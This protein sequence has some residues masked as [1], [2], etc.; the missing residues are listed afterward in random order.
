MS[1]RTDHH[2][3]AVIGAGQAGLAIGYFLAQRGRKFVILER[4]DDVAPAWR[5]RWD[6]LTLFTPRRY[7]SLPGL[8]FPG[9]PDGYP[10]RD[11]VLAYLQSYAARFDLPIRLA[12]AARR[13]ARDAERF[14]IETDIGTVTAD[15]VVI[16]TGPFQEPRI[17]SFAN[18][19][20][21]EVVQLHSTEYRSPTELPNGRTL[22]VGGGNTGY[23]IAD[24]LAAS[25]ETH[26]A[27]GAR[28]VPLPQRFLGRD[29][30]WWLTKTG[31]IN[32]SVETKVGRRAS[33]KET[34][35]GSRPSKAK[36]RG[37]ILHGRATD[38]AGRAVSFEDGSSIEVD[39]VLWSTG[40]RGD[41]GWIDLPLTDASGRIKQERGVTEIPGL[42]VLGLQW[43]YTRGSALLGFVKDDA[44]YI[45]E[46]IAARAGSSRPEL[47]AAGQGD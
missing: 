17:P 46:R 32:K 29:L 21:A 43:Q 15:Q 34:L 5:D 9:Q 25:R 13:L 20:A 39:A 24:E 42:Y 31:L 36:R 37:V 35:V 26:L 28:Q 33:Q 45:A 38:A 14:A 11:E 41:Y 8:E 40:F 44:A 30:F 7:D 19:L 1:E 4:S 3:V 6:S 27:V 12:T 2:E 10:N 47:V 22:I 23:Q 18:E 16:A